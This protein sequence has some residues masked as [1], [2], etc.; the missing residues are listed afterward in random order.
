MNNNNANKS[1][2]KTCLSRGTIFLKCIMGGA[3][4]LMALDMAALASEVTVESQMDRA[5]KQ[6]S[7]MLKPIVSPAPESGKEFVDIQCS[8]IKVNGLGYVLTFSAFGDLETLTLDGLS[9]LSDA[10]INSVKNGVAALPDLKMTEQMLM[11]VKIGPLLR[12]PDIK[13]DFITL[14]FKLADLQALI[15]GTLSSEGFRNE[16]Q[17]GMRSRSRY[18]YVFD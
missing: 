15:S 13:Y 12:G 4:V 16:T 5:V 11:V 7:D 6:M 10:F 9:N 17:V 14:Q 3:A 18:S 8:A 1:R 2:I